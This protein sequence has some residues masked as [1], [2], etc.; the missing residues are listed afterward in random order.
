MVAFDFH[1][2]HYSANLRSESDDGALRF[3]DTVLA[4][5]VGALREPNTGTF[6]DMPFYLG[7]RPIRPRRTGE[8][9]R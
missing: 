5:S 1:F 3:V 7:L 6:N 8:G 4:T 2:D 9:R